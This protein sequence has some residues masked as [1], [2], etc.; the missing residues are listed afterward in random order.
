MILDIAA[1]FSSPEVFAAA[2]L[3]VYISMLGLHYTQC[4]QVG[5]FLVELTQIALDF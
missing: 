2:H 5:Q 3:P 4:N 1:Q